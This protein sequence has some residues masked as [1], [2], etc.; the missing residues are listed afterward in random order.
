MVLDYRGGNESMTLTKQLD[1]VSDGLSKLL[2][3]LKDKPR[4]AAVLSADMRQ[5]QDVENAMFQLLGERFIDN[6]YGKQLDVVGRIV[7]QPREGRT[8][9]AYRAAL[10]AKIV[11][12]YSEGTP[13]DLIEVIHAMTPGAP[14][15]VTD[16]VYNWDLSRYT[17]PFGFSPLN[18][19]STFTSSG[20]PTPV[21][22]TNT[23]GYVVSA[24]YLD[25]G[26]RIDPTPDFVSTTFKVMAQFQHT[27]VASLGTIVQRDA[28]GV[29]TVR[30]TAPSNTGVW[31]AADITLNTADGTDIV[32]GATGTD[33]VW[34]DDIH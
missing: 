9:E 19:C 17:Y 24:A 26:A 31:N 20:T 29:P 34:A 33:R 5:A 7:N 8:D 25:S 1:H 3:Q 21:S 32:L 13:E 4:L 22:G 28:D 10:R 2:S 16:L 12:N 6:G 27:N 18:G 23:L 11:V 14:G 15:H 30:W